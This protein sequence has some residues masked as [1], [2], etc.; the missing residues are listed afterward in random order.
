MIR[1]FGHKWNQ[2]KGELQRQ[3]NAGNGHVFVP[4]KKGFVV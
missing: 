4:W 1:S 2:D 3:A